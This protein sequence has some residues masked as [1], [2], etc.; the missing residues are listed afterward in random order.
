M[1]LSNS[2]ETFQRLMDMILRGLLWT[3][4][5]VY[6]DDIVIYAHSHADLMHR[7]AEDF[8]RLQAA[9]LK[10]KPAKVRCSAS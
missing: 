9:N 4:V 8:Q 10:L 7:L 3:S 5:L 1:G 6:I 2:L